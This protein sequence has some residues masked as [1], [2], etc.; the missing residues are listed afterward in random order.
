M[1]NFLNFLK[2]FFTS[3]KSLRDKA[4]EALKCANILCK[5]IKENEEKQ[6]EY[7]QKSE[8]TRII[9][10]EKIQKK[11]KAGIEL[12][13]AQRK[14]SIACT[15]Y[16]DVEKHLKTL[17]DKCE[18]YLSAIDE[19]TKLARECNFVGSIFTKLL[20]LK[21]NHQKTHEIIT[22]RFRELS[23]INSSASEAYA[24]LEQNKA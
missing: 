20:G 18:F 4:D 7:F 2:F 14:Y 10:Q 22:E 8:G 19:K 17:L 3:E 24:Q 15:E 1:F 6:N 23:R 13:N 9:W 5:E 16:Q 21:R 12:E 11:N